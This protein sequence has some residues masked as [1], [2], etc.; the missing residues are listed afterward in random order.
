MHRRL[1]YKFV[2]VAPVLPL[3]G[4]MALS[5]VGVGRSRSAAASTPPPAPSFERDVLPL[6]KQYCVD[7]HSGKSPSGGIDLTLD[8]DLKG[9]LAHHD[10][11]DKVAS[12]VASQHMPPQGLPSP[13][14]AARD[15]MAGF[16]QST[17]S[18]ADCALH[19]PGRVTVRRLNRAEYDNTVRDLTGLDKEHL[20]DLPSADFPPDDVGYGFDNIGDVL[21]LSPMQM[22]K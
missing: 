17:L 7:C 21:S 2:P 11:W 6:V 16:V 19:D 1:L 22:E 13:A 5:V 14:L 10:L 9:M 18:K 12:N 4:L 20:P 8:H 3:I 15:R